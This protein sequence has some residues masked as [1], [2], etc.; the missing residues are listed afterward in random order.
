MRLKI[1]NKAIYG[2]YMGVDKK[3]KKVMFLD[4]ELG[5]IKLIQSSK[6]EKAYQK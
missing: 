3:T 1:K 2:Q 5:V 6:L 4:E